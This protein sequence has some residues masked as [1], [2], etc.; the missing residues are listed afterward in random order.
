M[1][2]SRGPEPG[3]NER[4]WQVVHAIPAGRVCTYGEV[5]RLAGLPGAARRVGAALKGLP[6]GTTLPWHRVINA[7]GRISLPPE[8]SAHARQ[9]ERLVAE[10]VQFKGN[11]AVD[12]RR[13]GWC[14]MP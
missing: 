4:I 11:G 13:F 12:L 3:I 7:R 10:G 14:G 8:S 6:R 5:A 1:Q 2:Q 9:R